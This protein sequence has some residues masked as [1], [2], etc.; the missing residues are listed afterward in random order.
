VLKNPF[1]TGDKV[2]ASRLENGEDH[3]PGTVI[4][5]YELLIGAE[6]KPMV[7]VEFEDGERRYLIGGAP[8][9]LPA[10]V[11]EQE[12]AGEEAG[13]GESEGAP[14]GAEA[15]TAGAEDAGVT[16]PENPEPAEG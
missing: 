5:A 13:K 1:R 15:E 2:L 3:E 6:S 7:V 12:A 16:A 11:S 8:N 14:A 4:D 9:V 10:P